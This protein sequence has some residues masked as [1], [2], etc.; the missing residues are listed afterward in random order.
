MFRSD[1]H[2]K[3]FGDGLCPEI[4]GQFSQNTTRLQYLAH[5]V[6]GHQALLAHPAK[7]I[8][9]LVGHDVGVV[10]EQCQGHINAFK[11]FARLFAPHKDPNKLYQ[12][13]A[14]HF[15]RFRYEYENADYSIDTG[16]PVLDVENY[17]GPAYMHY[18]NTKHDYQL[19]MPR[20][21]RN[22]EPGG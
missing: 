1:Q 8:K 4:A 5:V 7:E 6:Y 12:V 13:F 9:R 3:D 20:L 21:G 14:D 17:K 15:A 10:E 11:E 2:L 18:K 22:A 19:D 16:Q